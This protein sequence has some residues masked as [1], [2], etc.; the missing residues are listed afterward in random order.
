MILGIDE[1]GRGPWAGPMTVGA[2][3]LGDAIIEGLNDSK[4]L[5]KKR[6]EALEPEI[7][8]KAAATGIGWVS[9]AEIDTLGL[10]PALRLATIRAVK[11][12]DAKGVSY[13]EIIIDGTINFLEET[14]KGAYVETMPKADGLIPAVSAA[15]VIAKVARD[16]FM[17]E[18]DELYPGYGF[19][20]HA[21]YG[22]AKHRAA[23][24][25]LGVTPLQRLSFSPLKKYAAEERAV[26]GETTKDLGDAAERRVSEYLVT[27][28]HVI[29]ER[30]WRN[31]FCEIDIVSQCEDVLYFTEVKYRKTAQHGDGM[32]AITAKKLSQ[33]TFAAEFYLAKSNT[34]EGAA[35]LAVASVSGD[36]FTIDSWVALS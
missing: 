25:A 29:L 11:A 20:G 4:Q 3:V 30:N 32:E 23:I 24:E 35:Q 6:R 36:D 12:V 5:T 18:Q 34:S 22:T 9:A 33:M 13:D 2:V 10:G 1:A 26:R 27:N 8:E 19:G 7:L 28:G 21:G 17:A 31:R 16:R 15:S 14:G